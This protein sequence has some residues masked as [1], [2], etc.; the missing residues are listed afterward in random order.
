MVKIALI[1]QPNVGKSSLFNRLA[2]KRVAI[3]SEVSGTTRDI[4]RREINIFGR[5]ALMLDTGGISKVKKDST[6]EDG[7]EYEIFKNV[8]S[9]AI[10]AAKEAD[11]VLYMV[12]GKKL[13]DD[14]DRNFFYELQGLG[15]KLALVVNKIDN[16]K[17]LERLW[18]FYSFGIN[19][20]EMFG[21]SVSHNRGTK[22]L[23]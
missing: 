20:D 19:E 9:K 18:D 5:E 17:E 4:R 2:Q 23:F 16:D 7:S 12:D 10:E 1:G 11:I 22:R 14:D 8:K 13:P 21:M 15:K 3:V 6:M